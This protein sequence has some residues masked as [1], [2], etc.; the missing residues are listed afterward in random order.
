[1]KPD[2]LIEWSLCLGIAW[3]IL[4]SLTGVDEWVKDRF[5]TNSKTRKLEQCIAELEQ[6]L[7]ELEK[8]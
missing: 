4:S 7:A 6:R 5:G 3:L 1:M 2:S 8:K